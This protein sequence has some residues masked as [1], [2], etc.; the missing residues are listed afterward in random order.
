MV[1]EELRQIMAK[2][3]LRTIN[4]MIGR[5]DLLETGKA[6]DHWK[7]SG[8]DFS[9][10]LTPAEIVYEGTQVYRTIDQDHALDKA[11]DNVLIE[12][13]EPALKRGEKVHI[14]HDIVNINRVVGTMLSHEVAKATNGKLLPDDTIHIKLKGSAGQSLG[15]WLASGITLEVEGD[16]ND[17]VGKGQSGGRIIVYPPTSS[18]FKAEDNILIGN[19]V[20]YGATSGESYFRGIA[21]E[22]FCVRNSGANAVVEGIGD[23]GCEYMTGGRVVVLGKTGRNFGAGM[24]GGIA[25][26]WDRDGDFSRMCNTETFELESMESGDDINELRSMIANHQKYT[27]STV[28]E[29]ILNNWQTELPRFVKVM[30]TDYKRVLEEMAKE[31]AITAAT[32]S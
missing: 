9:S 22:R 31:T 20:M 27:G 29:S 8:L 1:A 32:G 15:A 18:T 2:L 24:S 19:V 6:V 25:Y 7:A 13:S 5:S 17:Y 30:P 10:I 26:V 3:G 21:A 11:L 12:L 23:H 16:A 28:A 14:E 4:D